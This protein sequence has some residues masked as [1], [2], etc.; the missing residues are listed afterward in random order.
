[1]R[2]KVQNDG[3]EENKFL[4]VSAFLSE[5]FRTAGSHR[6]GYQRIRSGNEEER[7][8]EEREEEREEREETEIVDRRCGKRFERSERVE[9]TR[10]FLVL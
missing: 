10:R 4:M 5:D 6:I 3:L 9:R 7:G 8:G 2:G 1:M